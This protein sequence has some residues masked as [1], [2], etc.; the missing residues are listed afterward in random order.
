MLLCPPARSDE[1]EGE[2]QFVSRTPRAAVPQLPSVLSRGG[3][4]SQ[5]GQQLK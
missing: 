1:G 4:V 2:K 3:G 5:G